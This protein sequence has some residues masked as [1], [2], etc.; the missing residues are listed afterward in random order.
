MYLFI[1]E[2]DAVEVRSGERKVAFSP[3][4]RSA[5]HFILITREELSS[6]EKRNLGAAL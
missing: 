2:F 5:T 6:R 4:L 3:L 1:A